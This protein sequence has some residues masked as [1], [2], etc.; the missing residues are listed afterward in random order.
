MTGAT[1]GECAGRRPHRIHP[2][3]SPLA[4]G[5]VADRLRLVAGRVLV[6]E[7]PGPGIMGL[8]S[9]DHGVAAGTFGLHG[10]RF[11]SPD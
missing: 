5:L 2:V 1:P 3:A 10:V 7:E 8:F 6:G 4:T 9:S 11:V